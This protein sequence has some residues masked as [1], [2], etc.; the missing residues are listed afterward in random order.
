MGGEAAPVE[1]YLHPGDFWFG[2]AGHRVSTLLGSCVAI[3]LWHP[4]RR[5]GGMC[6]YV[7]PSRGMPSGERLDGRYGDEA[8]AMF[9]AELRRTHTRPAQYQVRIFGGSTM[10]ADPDAK[11]SMATKTSELSVA[12]RN[13]EAARRLVDATGFTVRAEN[14]GGASYRKLSFDVDS[15]EIRLWRGGQARSP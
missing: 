14:M 2:G 3:A 10:F 4:Q 9:L 5:L 13:I 7:L 15:G 6:H 8:M 1:I 11:P 12:Y